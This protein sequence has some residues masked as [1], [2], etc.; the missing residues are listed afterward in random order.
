MTIFTTLYDILGK[1]EGERDLRFKDGA[2]V[3]PKKIHD[4]S[5]E[6]EQKN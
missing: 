6:R 2:T 4:S 5:W 1:N 3:I